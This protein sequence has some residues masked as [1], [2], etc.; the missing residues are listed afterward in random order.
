MRFTAT[1]NNQYIYNLATKGKAQG[2]YTVTVSQRDVRASDRDDQ[3]E[4]VAPVG[5][6]RAEPWTAPSAPATVAGNGG[7]PQ[8]RP[9]SNVRLPV[10]PAGGPG[11]LAAAAPCGR[12][13]GPPGRGGDA[14][15]G[16]C[17]RPPG[18]RAGAPCGAAH[19]AT[20]G[21]TCRT[22]PRRPPGHRDG[23]PRR[24]RPVLG[25]ARHSSRVPLPERGHRDRPAG[26]RPRVA[27][28]RRPSGVV[29]ASGREAAIGTA[30][31]YS[32]RQRVA[33]F[34]LRP[35]PVAIHRAA[36]GR[37]LQLIR[38]GPPDR[39]ERAVACLSS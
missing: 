38:A 12:P 36:R 22:G 21:A 33:R 39:R 18:H 28:S 15:T 13:T 11:R 5:R 30:A 9:H 25:P 29:L 6:E 17:G 32:P 14:A 35:V 34:L 4:E 24:G 7:R 3:H 10:P 20:A 37:R 19:R 8:G 27:M 26:R 23:A 1:P 31:G 16:R 2:D